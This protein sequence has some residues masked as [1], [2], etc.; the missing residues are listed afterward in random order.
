MTIN[1]CLNCAYFLNC[2]KASEEVREC[3]NYI[4]RI[5]N[6]EKNEI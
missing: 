1:I 2:S 4:K 6:G 3:N 5:D